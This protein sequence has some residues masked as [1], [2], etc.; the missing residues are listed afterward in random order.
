M[1]S[2]QCLPGV[3]YASLVGGRDVMEVKAFLFIYMTRLGLHG[4]FSPGPGV[5]TDTTRLV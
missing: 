1:F 5:W 3:D 4:M 2:L